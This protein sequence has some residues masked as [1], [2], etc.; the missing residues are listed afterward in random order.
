MSDGA[1]PIQRVTWSDAVELYFED[2]EPGQSFALGT[3][4]VTEAEIVEFARRFDP[5]PFHIGEESARQT[6]FGGLIAS[7][8]HTG[9]MWMRLYCDA[10]LLRSAS[11]GSPGV[12]Q[13]RW[14]SPVRP[15]DVLSGSVQVLS[16]NASA[17]NPYRGTVVASGALHD[18]QGVAKMTLV[19]RGLFGRRDPADAD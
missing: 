4:R 8:W 9:A 6:V 13:I 15:G 17:T 3:H 18:A 16:A 14:L 11:M 5:Q 10:V 12:E 1:R 2:F 7:G 19:A